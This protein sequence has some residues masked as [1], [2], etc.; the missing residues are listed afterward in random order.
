[1]QGKSRINLVEKVHLK[2]PQKVFFSVLLFVK[3]LRRYD[4]RDFCCWYKM[5]NLIFVHGWWLIVYHRIITES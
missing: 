5:G 1:M 2:L 3:T 4:L